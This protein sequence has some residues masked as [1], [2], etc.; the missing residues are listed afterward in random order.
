MAREFP[1]PS[2]IDERVVSPD[3]PKWWKLG[4]LG[5]SC[6]KFEYFHKDKDY[7]QLMYVS[8]ENTEVLYHD[9]LW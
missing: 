6:L 3:P 7:A 5:D 9:A 2:S 1:D 4:S 8:I